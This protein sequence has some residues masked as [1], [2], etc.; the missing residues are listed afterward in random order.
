MPT[1]LGPL[2]KKTFFGACL[3]H[4]ELEKNELSKYCI[5]CDSDLCKHCISTNKH[6]DHDQL[7]IY[8]NVYKEVVLLEQME[9]HTDCK[10]IQVNLNLYR[11]LQLEIKV[12]V[13]L[14]VS[15][16]HLCLDPLVKSTHWCEVELEQN[17][18]SLITFG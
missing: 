13:L 9:K 16:S 12:S 15:L 10:L 18:Q 5:T 11:R 3:V 7:K 1:W 8:R 17:D 14:A 2:L 6:N 4:D